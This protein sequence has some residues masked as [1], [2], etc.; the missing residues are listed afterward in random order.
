M[1]AF[2]Q[3]IKHL[4]KFIQIPLFYIYIFFIIV[5]LLVTITTFG[6][7]NLKCNFKKKHETILYS[8]HW[9]SFSD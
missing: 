6:I 1:I 2:G 8:D 3:N 9:S 7:L 5:V 4:Y